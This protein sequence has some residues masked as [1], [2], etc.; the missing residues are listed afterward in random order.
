MPPIPTVRP[1]GPAM[2]AIRGL[3]GLSINQLSTKAEVALS[4]ISYYE[5]DQ[6]RL[7]REVLDRI[8]TALEV[9][10]QAICMDDLADDESLLW[11]AS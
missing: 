10:A 8:A 11:R 6:K 9:P 5:R 3:K 7:S 2:R 4:A 1:N